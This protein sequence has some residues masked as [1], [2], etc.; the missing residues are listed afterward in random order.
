MEAAAREHEARQR[1]L[2]LDGQAKRPG[3]TEDERQRSTEYMNRVEA[4][5][6]AREVDRNDEGLTDAHREQMEE[7]GI[8]WNDYLEAEREVAEQ[9][10]HTQAMQRQDPDALKRWEEGSIGLNRED[11]IQREEAQEQTIED[12]ELTPEELEIAAEQVEQ[13]QTRRRGLGL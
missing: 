11:D 1:E 2:G 7:R 4:R 10:H 9:H 5:R 8:D 6:I 12:L 3:L 13:K